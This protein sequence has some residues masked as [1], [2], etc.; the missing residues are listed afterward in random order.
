MSLLERQDLLQLEPISSKGALQLLPLGK[1]NK[2]CKYCP[3]FGWGALDISCTAKISCWRRL[4]HCLL[5][6]VQERRASSRLPEQGWFEFQE[7]IMNK[8]TPTQVFNAPVSCLALGGPVAK[9]DKVV[10][11]LYVSCQPTP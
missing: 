2:V 10:M 6:R 9:R 8:P 11:T 7:L 3:N 4:R 5:L 1:K